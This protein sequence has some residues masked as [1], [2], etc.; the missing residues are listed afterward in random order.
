MHIFMIFHQAFRETMK[1]KIVDAKIKGDSEKDG[2][3][4]EIKITV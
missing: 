4:A 1:A 2:I 3:R